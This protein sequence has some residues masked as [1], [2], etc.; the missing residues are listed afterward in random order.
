LK[1]VYCKEIDP[2]QSGNKEE[3]LIIHEIVN[4]C[5]YENKRS[6]LMRQCRDRARLLIKKY[7]AKEMESLKR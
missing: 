5:A 1:E 4:S 3:W 7:K 6:V 2:T